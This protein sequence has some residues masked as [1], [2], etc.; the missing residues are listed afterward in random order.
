MKASTNK[1]KIAITLTVFYLLLVVSAFAILFA[2]KKDD[3]LAGI[4]VVM[5]AMPW[6][7]FLTWLIETLSI[8]SMAFNTV[9]MAVGC[10][11]N[12]VILYSSVS[13][14]ARIFRRNP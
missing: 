6:S 12:A 4:F 5:V 11:L 2:A 13:F 1:S 10:F 14:I 8:E 3:S 7:I 9:F